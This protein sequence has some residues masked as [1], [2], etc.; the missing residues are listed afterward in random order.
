M[1]SRSA[2]FTAVLERELHTLRRTRMVWMLAAGFLVPTVGTALLSGRSGYVPL[3]LALM[4]PLELL[5]P[6]FAAALGYRAV[7]ADRERGE[8]TMLRTY[9]VDPWAFTLGIYCGRLVV[10]L[11]IVVGLL[12][13]AGIIVPVVEP[14]PAA[15][16]RTSGLDSPL[17]YLRFIVLTA[18]FSAVMLALMILLSTVVRNARRGLIG[19]LVAVILVAVGFDLAII[20]G[21]AGDFIAAQSLLAYLVLSP[22]SAYRGLVLALVVAPVATTAVKLAAPIASLVSLGFWLLLPLVTASLRAWGPTSYTQN[23][24]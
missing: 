18:V 2:H 23:A 16:T 6:A 1:T 3:S 7:L 4:T 5:I 15:L 24:P 17:Y 13:V 11:S 14:S 21:L 8:I 9:P 10:F 12:L 20:L 19:A 22:A